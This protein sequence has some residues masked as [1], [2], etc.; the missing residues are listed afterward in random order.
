MYCKYCINTNHNHVLAACVETR[1]TCIIIIS[2]LDVTLV[3][4][5]LTLYVGIS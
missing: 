5:T 4:G 3:V 2:F 1:K